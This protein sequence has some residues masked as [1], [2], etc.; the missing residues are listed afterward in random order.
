MQRVELSDGLRQINWVAQLVLH[1]C[2]RHAMYCITRSPEPQTEIEIDAVYEESLVIQSDP[3]E[4]ANAHQIPRSNRVTDLPGRLILLAAFGG[5][6]WRQAYQL[7]RLFKCCLVF[8]DEGAIH[9]TVLVHGQQPR[10]S[11]FPRALHSMIQSV[12][13][14]PVFSQTL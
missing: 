1:H 4:H 2:G 14:T 10:T 3:L 13:N 5:D 11:C 7:R 9:Y 12:S 8:R 6:P